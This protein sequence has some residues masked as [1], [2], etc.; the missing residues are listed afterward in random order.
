MRWHNCRLIINLRTLLKT[1]N[2]YIMNW[3]TKMFT[4]SIGQ[5]LLVALTGLFLCTFLVIHAVGNLQLFKNDGGMSFNLYTVFMTTN[6]LIKTVS[7]IL[8]FSILFHAF[9]GLALA[10]KNRQARPVQYAV[11]DG[12]SNSHWTSRNMGILGTI[13]LVFI[14][15]HMSD[16]WAE[17]K[18]GHIPYV[19][20][21]Q[22]MTTGET[23]HEPYVDANGAPATIDKKMEEYVVGDTKITIV[24]DLFEEVE[25]EFQNLGLVLL[26]VFSMFAVAFHLFHGFQ[27]GFQTLGLNHPRYNPAIRFLGLWVFSIIIPAL[28]ASMPLY[29]YFIK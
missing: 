26:Y 16:F 24:K 23:T 15:V 10:Y 8:Y 14:V 20:Y 1:K 6:P 9:K 18:F 21:T 17:Y 28:F 3:I 4:S 7:Y 29:F 5:K 27:S 25:E 12:K 22:N 19:K 13:M 2:R 11:V